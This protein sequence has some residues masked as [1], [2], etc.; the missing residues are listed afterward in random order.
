MLLAK[1]TRF[2]LASRKIL[3]LSSLGILLLAVGL[4]SASVF[5]RIF[6]PSYAAAL[7]PGLLV[8]LGLAVSVSVYAI[9]FFSVEHVN[10]DREFAAT[11][12]ESTSIFENVL[13]GILILDNEAKCLDVNPAA[14]SILRISRDELIG[15]NIRTFL[16][17]AETFTKDW[18]GFLRRNGQRGRTELITKDGTATVVDFS[19]AANY[20]PGRH[21]FIL[22]D[23]TERTQAEK[24]LRES[25][26][27]FQDVANN[28]QEIIWTMNADTK[29][30]AYVNRAYTT[31]T[32]HSIEGLHRNPASYRELIFPQDRIRVLSK[33]QDVLGS[34]FFD[35]EFRFIHAG[36]SVRWIWVKAH[37]VIDRR[38]RWIVGTAQDITSRKEAERQIADHLDATEAARAEAEALRKATLALSQNL[39]MDSVLD[40]LLQCIGQLVPF[41]RASVLFIDDPEH[42]FVAR[43]A[44]RTQ[45]S[46]TICTLRASDNHFLQKVL[47]EHKAMIISDTTNE[48]EWR[49]AAP[50]DRSR[51]WLGIPLIAADHVVGVLSLSCRTP[52]IFN[53]EHLRLAKNLAVSAAVAIE[54]ARAHERAEIYGAELELRLQ[55]L[56]KAQ[57][58]C[59]QYEP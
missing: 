3:R 19:A 43:E 51:S 42:I 38:G 57:E 2:P 50:F 16:R 5:L 47:F 48:P 9:W 45:P 40:T 21:L 33:L 17:S 22:C 32:G 46:T 31:I 18:E 34:G 49:D 27:R 14:A 39:A 12:C 41:D 7:V 54:N 13:D 26:E 36:G 58:A 25:E 10:S 4:L 23:V 24:A 20:L 29:T 52:S 30:V 15:K 53:A 6:Q 37:V 56:R 11:S 59:R 35:E 55:Q 1:L 28:I 8:A 44:P